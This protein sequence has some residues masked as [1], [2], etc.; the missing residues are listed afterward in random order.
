M[1]AVSAAVAVGT[2]VGGAVAANEAADAQKDAAKDALAYQERQSKRSQERL[3]PYKKA[4]YDALERLEY[5]AGG[6]APG[7]IDAELIGKPN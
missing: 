1:G 3:D 6:D 4:G 7:V 5:F 2:A